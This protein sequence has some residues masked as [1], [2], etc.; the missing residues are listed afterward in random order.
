[1]R[2]SND[3]DRQAFLAWREANP[4]K[5]SFHWRAEREEREQLRSQLSY[6]LGL[7]FHLKSFLFG[8]AAGMFL[9]LFL[10]WLFASLFYHKEIRTPDS[11]GWGNAL[12]ADDFNSGD[13]GGQ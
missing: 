1:M 2:K 4:G 6:P 11:F 9:V 5:H 8:M 12:G 13:E 7:P 10:I 3:T